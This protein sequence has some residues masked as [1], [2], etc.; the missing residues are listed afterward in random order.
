MN[1]KLPTNHPQVRMAPLADI[2]P[3]P[4]HP[5]THTEKAI[6]LLASGIERWGFLVPIVVDERG[7]I[8]A[9]HARYLAAKHLRL[10]YVPVLEA[11][12]I[13]EAD[14][15][16]FALAD[17]KIAEYSG[18]NPKLLQ[19]ELNFLFESNYDFDI[20]GFSLADLD[21]SIVE[22]QAPLNSEQVELPDPDATAVSRIGDLWLI[23][24]HRL[25]SPSAFNRHTGCI[26]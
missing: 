4:K 14:R 19:E 8:V 21:F 16:A 5:R 10:E 2:K 1:I 22:A 26:K 12:F 7:M 23:G 15:R 24:T 11:C 25:C 6:L 13:T 9:G 20:T 3:N 18:W 17:N